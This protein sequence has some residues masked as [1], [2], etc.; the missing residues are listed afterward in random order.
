M[1]K[2][3]EYYRER[4]LRR[5]KKKRERTK[6]IS[7][8]NCARTKEKRRILTGWAKMLRRY[9]PCK[10]CNNTYDA[11]C[12]SFD[13]CRGPKKFLIGGGKISTKA[14]FVREIEKC[15]IVCRW[16]H[17][18][19]EHLRGLPSFQK[20]GNPTSRER[21]KLLLEK[22]TEENYIFGASSLFLDPSRRV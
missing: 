21:V 22:Y 2:P 6:T 19:R 1:N 3:P 15:D 20:L 18:A 8:K 17:D 14:S 12:M 10:D 13:H 16:C 7:K 5:K 11:S 4:R 9:I